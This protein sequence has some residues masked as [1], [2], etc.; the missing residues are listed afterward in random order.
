MQKLLSKKRL[1]RNDAKQLL[2][3]FPEAVARVTSIDQLIKIGSDVS[4]K[5]NVPGLLGH[6]EVQG[7]L[8]CAILR[9]SQ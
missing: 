2:D 1:S 4:D 6:Q 3:L 5:R 9:I 8:A 7:A